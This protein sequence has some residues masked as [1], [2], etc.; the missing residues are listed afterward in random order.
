MVKYTV[1]TDSDKKHWGQF[2]LIEQGLWGVLTKLGEQKNC[3]GFVVNILCISTVCGALLSLGHNSVHCHFGQRGIFHNY[4]LGHLLDLG[5]HSCRVP[6]K[7]TV[8]SLFAPQPESE[9]LLA[10]QPTGLT[11][12]PRR[13]CWPRPLRGTA[14]GPGYC[15]GLRAARWENSPCSSV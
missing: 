12:S 13:R 15:W 2:W 6:E 11:C 7:H 3:F 5:H 4:T 9:H 14:A 10:S 8:H 1:S